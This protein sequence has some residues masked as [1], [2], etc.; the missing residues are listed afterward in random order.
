MQIVLLKLM[1]IKL[2]EG[3]HFSLDYRDIYCIVINKLLSIMIV[4][5]LALMLCQHNASFFHENKP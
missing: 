3:N 2:M 1:E 4:I 5:F